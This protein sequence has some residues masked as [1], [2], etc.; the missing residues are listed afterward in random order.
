MG[1]VESLE[2][3]AAGV[4]D[5]NAV[6]QCA[7][8]NGV[9]PLL[10]RAVRNESAVPLAIRRE[11]DKRF[12]VKAGHNALLARELQQILLEFQT[13]GVQAVAYKGPALAVMAYG[14]LAYRN[15]SS[16]IDLLLRKD[17]LPR[18]KDV[19]H[20]RG[21]RVSLTGD[22]EQHFLQYRYHLH[23]ERR[24]PEIHVELHWAFTPAY[25]PFPLDFWSRVQ[26]VQVTGTPVV[27]LD[28]EC[29][30]L[31]LFA[32]GAKEDWP[33]LSQVL[34]V[35]QVIRSHPGMDWNWVFAEARRMRRERVLRLGLLLAS[36]CIATPLPEQVTAEIAR[37]RKLAGV[38]DEI[39]RKFGIGGRVHFLANAMRIWHHP[40]DR[41]LCLAY[42]LRFLPSRLRTLVWPAELERE[43]MES[44][45]PNAFFVMSRLGRAI[46]EHGLMGVLR[47]ARSQLW[48]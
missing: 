28:P 29:T 34:D 47:Q 33:K 11:L 21:Y 9:V 36:K 18:A 1:T 17:D 4:A 39:A 22:E 37:E 45:G 13:A 43:M 35:G 42:V 7:S 10:A 14:D 46:R 8:N 48:L 23:C 26:P 12:S 15:P 40:K 5:W 27:T 31:A 19:V 24:D 16:D 2:P 38:V 44:P 20:A 30:L 25:W 32:H 41:L 3:L 6:L